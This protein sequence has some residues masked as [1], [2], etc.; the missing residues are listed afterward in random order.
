MHS[1]R[2]WSVRWMIVEWNVH[3]R[4]QVVQPEKKTSLTVK[5]EDELF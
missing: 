1:K 5:N 2:T 3:A 4:V